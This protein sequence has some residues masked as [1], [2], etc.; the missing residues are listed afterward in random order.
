MRG[1]RLALGLRAIRRGRVSE[2]LQGFRERVARL[3]FAALFGD[4]GSDQLREVWFRWL[5]WRDRMRV[6]APVSQAEIGVPRSARE[7]SLYPNRRS[8]QPRGLYGARGRF[9]RAILPSG[10]G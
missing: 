5:Q 8:T 9:S 7:V 3:G 6:R 2:L 10:W 1:C 4:G